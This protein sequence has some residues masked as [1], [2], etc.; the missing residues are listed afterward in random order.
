MLTLT[1]PALIILLLE[2]ALRADWVRVLRA[3]DGDRALG[4][5]RSELPSLIILDM[6]IPGRNGIEV[7]STLRGEQDARLR[8]VPILMLTGMKLKETDLVAAFV[9]GATDFLTK[10]IKPTL[11]RSRVRSWLLRTIPV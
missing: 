11:V 8:D 5:A 10:P 4:L 3:E 6:Q 2:T 7:C 9:A 1:G